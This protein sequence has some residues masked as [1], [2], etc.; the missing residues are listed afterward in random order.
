MRLSSLFGRT[1]RET[2][3]DAEMAS[4]RL[5]LRA[6]M[7]RPL[8]AGIY[9]LLPLGQR[10]AVRMEAI[11]RAEM[12][13]IGAQEMLM[14]VLHP[15]EVWQASGRWQ[16]LDRTLFRLQD[17]TER[18]M[19]LAMTHEEVFAQ[20]LDRE[21][22]S[23]RQLPV[24]VYHVQTKFRD[25]RRPR[26]G[27]VR[28]R[29]FTMVDAY[30][31]HVD[32]ADLEAFYPTMLAAYRRIFARCGVDPI[33]V[34]ADSGIMGGSASHEFILPNPDGEDTIVFCAECGYAANAEHATSLKAP[35]EPRP[36]VEAPVAVATPGCKTI[37]D[38]ARYLGVPT[39]Q[40]LKAVFFAT[41][42]E[43]PQLVFAVIRGDL[44]VNEVKL[45]NAA[46]VG[47]LRAAEA[48][49]IR[50]VG[51]V[52]G[53]ASPIGVRGARVI[54]DDSVHLGGGYVVG[55]NREG[56]HLTG[57]EYG[58]DF[59][60]EVVTDIALARAGERCPRCKGALQVDRGIE[61]GHCFKLGT[62]YTGPAWIHYLDADGVEHP[63]VM[64]SYGIGVGRLI[65]AVVEEHHDEHGICWPA[66]VAPYQV[67]IVSL[68]RD[69]GEQAEA[70]ALYERASSA[71]LETLYD[72]RV[73]P[74][75]GVKF[76]DADL[77]GC[78]LR[79]TV[80]RRS[81]SQGG[82]EAKWRDQDERDVIPLDAVIEAAQAGLARR[83]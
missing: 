48:D 77:I 51:A 9:T 73:G 78:P 53:Y 72:D 20:L 26:G 75:A 17:R 44:E 21:V 82:V 47:A 70:D 18:D 5:L 37:E 67:H 50:A 28:V 32:Q 69:E 38:V 59:A 25:E 76:N 54:A 27:L 81:L 57:V 29:E 19:A 61:L 24:L 66:S 4:H 11:L 83:R 63:I 46:G 41:E 33:A 16:T 13:G 71:G 74:S 8:G 31:A 34:E 12:D 40:T 1:L 39:A 23:Y 42:E 60:A 52:P 14:P 58:R 64:G 10:V 56:Y 36:A 35:L 3:A 7:I 43:T 45:A 55:A 80:S 6:G 15:A 49:E 22:E 65:A 30:S 68:V 62:R 2:P 79:L